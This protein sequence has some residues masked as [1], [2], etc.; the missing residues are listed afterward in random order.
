MRP[1]LNSPELLLLIAISLVTGAVGGLIGGTMLG[2]LGSL[3]TGGKLQVREESAT[4]EVARKISPAVV[5]ITGTGL[6]QD[7]DLFGLPS[8]RQTQNA[9]TGFLVRADGLI[10]T[11][12]HVVEGTSTLKVI[13]SDGV[14]HDAKVVGLDPLGDLAL[15]KIPGRPFPVA[16]LGSTEQLVVGTHVVA[17][18]NA[19]GHYEGTVTSGVIS[20]IG[21]AITAGDA[22]GSER[23]DN[24]IQTDAAINPGNSGGPLVDLAGRVIGINTAIDQEGQSIGFALPV[25]IVKTALSSYERH[26]EIRRP[27]LGVRY[28]PL[29]PQSVKQNELKVSDGA[30]LKSSTSE[31]AVIPGG[32]ADQA[33]LREGDILTRVE[34]QAVDRR[35]PLGLLIQNH[36]PGERVAITYFRAGR[37]SSTKVTLSRAAAD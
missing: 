35:H 11:N 4:S 27:L 36:D 16:S 12:K 10:V 13:T 28:L 23:L 33:G 22:T 6:A 30:W 21:R 17:I 26:G 24:V 18:G 3:S 20:A 37:S 32:P 1:K 34:G 2:D 19:L 31:P 15:L 25:E 7:F 5:S 9:G 14:E 29:T 8:A